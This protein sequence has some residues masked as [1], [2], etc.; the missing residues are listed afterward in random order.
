MAAEKKSVPASKN[1]ETGKNPVSNQSLRMPKQSM[2]PQPRKL[3][4]TIFGPPNNMG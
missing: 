2:Q 4:T 3:R 1:P